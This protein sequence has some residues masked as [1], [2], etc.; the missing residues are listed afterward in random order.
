MQIVLDWP[1]AQMF[2]G[3]GL[4][5]FLWLLGM[6]AVLVALRVPR[7]AIPW[8]LIQCVLLRPGRRGSDDVTLNYCAH[9]PTLTVNDT[10]AHKGGAS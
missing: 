2:L 6:S 5:G 8:L 1:D 4:C 7:N 9:E 3:Y 10:R